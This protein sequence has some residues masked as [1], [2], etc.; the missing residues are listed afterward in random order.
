[1][2]G[3]SVKRTCWERIGGGGATSAIETVH[4]VIDGS[5]HVTSAHADGNNQAVGTCLERELR[6]WVFPPSGSTTEVSVPYKFQS[7]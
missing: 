5:G 2:H 1:M 3:A 6:N 4:L 7:Q